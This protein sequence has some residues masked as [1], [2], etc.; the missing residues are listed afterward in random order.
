MGRGVAQSASSAATTSVAPPPARCTIATIGRGIAGGGIQSSRGPN[1]FYVMR[2]RQTSEA[3]P[4]PS[5]V[6]AFSVALSSLYEHIRERQYEDPHLFVIRDI[7]RHGGAKKVTIGDDEVLR[8]Q[9]RICVPNADGLREL[10]LE[11]ARNSR[12]SIHLSAAKI[13]QDLRQHYWRRSM[14]KDIIAYVAQCLNCQQVKY[15]H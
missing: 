4:D 6:L 3:F 8:M 11:E 10:I 2:R 14:K 12:Y 1:K 13:Y 15:E 7:V 5:H 9:D